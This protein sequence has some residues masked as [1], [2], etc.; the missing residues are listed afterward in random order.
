[1]DVLGLTHFCSA[2]INSSSR[3]AV[4]YLTLILIKLDL[5]IIS[6]M[7]FQHSERSQALWFPWSN[8]TKIAIIEKN[9]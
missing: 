4:T 3:A 1:M 2:E 8:V 9:Y 7:D 5:F 6:S